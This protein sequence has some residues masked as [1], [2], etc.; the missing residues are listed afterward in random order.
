VFRASSALLVAALVG[1]SHPVP[2]AT[3]EGAVRAW[4]E[5]ME[6]SMGSPGAAMDAYALL[7]PKA[8]ANLEA[9]AQRAAQIEGRRALGYEMMAE[10]RF[11][12][13]FRPK[14]MHAVVVGDQATV[15]V[16]GADPGTEHANVAC[17]KEADGWHVEPE[18]PEIAPPPRKL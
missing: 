8:K 2:N 13:K 12:L 18:L 17:I 9:R 4:L 11:G 14:A 6:E 16:T 1:C 7:G 10:G 3:P 15:E 5:H